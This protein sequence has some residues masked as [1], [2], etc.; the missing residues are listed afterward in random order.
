MKSQNDADR[1]GQMDQASSA[2][3][4]DQ[5]LVPASALRIVLGTITMVSGFLIAGRWND[6]WL[7]GVGLAIFILSSLI[8]LKRPE[9]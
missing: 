8:M 7:D 9:N 3:E 6:S 4:E 5:L 2:G 1:I